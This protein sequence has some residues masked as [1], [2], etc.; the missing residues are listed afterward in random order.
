MHI[1]SANSRERCQ[2]P[3]LMPRRAEYKKR[4]KQFVLRKKNDASRAIQ[5]SMI[6]SLPRAQFRG[7]NA[8][9]SKIKNIRAAASRPL[10]TS[11]APIE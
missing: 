4:K 2:V 1:A 7:S 6:Q 5:T 3:L 10:F 9:Y 11:G 8:S